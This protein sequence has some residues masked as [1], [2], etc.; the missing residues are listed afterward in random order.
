MPMSPSSSTELMGTQDQD[1][2]SSDSETCLNGIRWTNSSWK[3]WIWVS[4][5][6]CIRV[7][8][9][10]CAHGLVLVCVCVYVCRCLCVCVGVGGGAVVFGGGGGGQG[11]FMPECVL[12]GGW[13]RLCLCESECVH[14]CVMTCVCACLWVWMCEW[15]RV[16][17][18]LCGCTCEYALKLWD[19]DESNAHLSGGFCVRWAD[20]GA[21]WTWQQWLPPRLVPGSCGD[22]QHGNQR[23]HSLPL[24]QV[25][26][27]RQGRQRDFAWPL[28]QVRLVMV[29][30]ASKVDQNR[31]WQRECG[32]E[33]GCFVPPFQLG[34]YLCMH[35]QLLTS[36]LPL[37]LLHD[38]WPHSYIQKNLNT[39][40]HI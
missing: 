31:K 13:M 25:V 3:H 38:L 28:S 21:H 24:Q 40:I 29:N 39:L 17:V 1:P 23:H 4:V 30:C 14:V 11:T 37:F 26:W 20:Q 36:P 8:V 18:S 33:S 27:S 34:V 10:V 35:A 9:R 32:R 19:Y 15:E 12:Q 22:H 5:S 2:W 6:V 16:H 7:C